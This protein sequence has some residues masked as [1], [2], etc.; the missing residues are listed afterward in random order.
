M[1]E[2]VKKT[3]KVTG[4]VWLHVREDGKTKQ[5]F[6]ER[7]LDKAIEYAERMHLPEPPEEV[8]WTSKQTK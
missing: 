6:L 2:I 8:I 7:N 5:I 3:D 4:E 1:I